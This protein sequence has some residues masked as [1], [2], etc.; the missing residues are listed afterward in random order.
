MFTAMSLIHDMVLGHPLHLTLSI[1]WLVTMLWPSL[2]GTIRCFREKAIVKWYS[3]ALVHRRKTFPDSGHQPNCWGAAAFMN[4]GVTVLSA[5]LSLSACCGFIP[6]KPCKSGGLKHS[7]PGS[8]CAC[9]EP[10]PSAAERNPVLCFQQILKPINFQCK[11]SSDSAHSS[12][13]FIFL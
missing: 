8:H 13:P 9:S 5:A 6:A 4:Q 11:T 2:E 3:G 10:G 7:L 12:A 1:H